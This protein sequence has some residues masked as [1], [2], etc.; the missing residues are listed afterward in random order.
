MALETMKE[1][2]KIIQSLSDYPNQEEGLTAQEMKEK[3]DEA[4]VRLQQYLNGSVVPALNGKL[5]EVRLNEAVSDAVELA[6]QSFDLEKIGAAPSGYGYG[7]LAIQ[8]GNIANE[9]VL[10]TALSSVYDKMEPT[11]TK[12]VTYVDWTAWRWFGILSK[13]SENN[14]SFV[15]HSAVYGGGK[16]VKTKNSGAW[17]PVEWENPPM[18]PGVEYRT[19]E[20]WNGNVKYKKLI[21]YTTA[22]ALTGSMTLSIPHG[23]SGL[24][25]VLSIQ[26]TTN[27]YVLPYVTAG[28]SL[29]ISGWSGTNVT[30]YVNTPSSW[31]A[32]RD[33]YIELSYTKSN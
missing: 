19:I 14:G 7:G 25:T 20:R 10:E 15:A 4:G 5:D 31:S 6:F 16:I 33:W 17:K 8:L 2:V 11:E 29:S 21:K 30:M 24:S 28:S 23:I 27:G 3:F 26:S 9:T 12:L 13:S 32:G 18:M 22:E 1:S